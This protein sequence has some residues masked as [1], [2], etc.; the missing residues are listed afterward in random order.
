MFF[1]S[2]T[3]GRDSFK[4]NG[5]PGSYTV[6]TLSGKTTNSYW[7]GTT[8]ELNLLK[9]V[10]TKMLATIVPAFTP[11]N[12]MPLRAWP[13]FLSYAGLALCLDGSIS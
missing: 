2:D 7:D 3:G 6:C 8:P 4:E 12:S 11:R 10:I 5:T 1:C 9:A 13:T